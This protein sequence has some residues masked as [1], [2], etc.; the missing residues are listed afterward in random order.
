MSLTN[1]GSKA[2]LH[3]LTMLQ[4]GE[5]KVCVTKTKADSSNLTS[6]GLGIKF[7]CQLG[8]FFVFFPPNKAQTWTSIVL[9]PSTAILPAKSR[10]RVLF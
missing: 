8:E 9:T 5:I 6:F 1:S 10:E 4:C 7:F 3:Q 2:S